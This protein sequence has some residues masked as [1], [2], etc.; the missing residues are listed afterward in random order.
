MDYKNIDTERLN[1]N[2][3]NIDKLETLKIVKLINDEDKKVAYAVEKV[4]PQIAEAIDSAVPL[5]KSGGR[6]IYVGAGTSGRLGIVDAAECPPTFGVSPE[7]VQGIIAG[8]RDSMFRSSEG[9]EDNREAAVADLKNIGFGPEDICCAIS[10][11]GSAEYCISALKYASSLGALCICICCNKNAPMIQYSKIAIIP[12]VGPEVIAGST[13]MKAGTAQKMV[14]NMISTGIMIRLGRVKGNM[15]SYMSPVNKKLRARAV[16]IIGAQTG[17][18]EQEAKAA[19]ELSDGNIME[20]ISR[21]QE[22]KKISR[23]TQFA[24]YRKPKADKACLVRYNKNLPKAAI[25]ALGKLILLPHFGFKTVILTDIVKSL[26]V[27]VIINR[28]GNP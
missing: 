16:R 1:E 2:T 23:I 26:G 15:M 3:L 12:E 17:S 4:L 22:Q 6:L 8:G 9:A 25:A 7:L 13:R 21:L 20:A 10:A 11:S 18:T 27:A 28:V 24:Y 5:L 14:L 19:L